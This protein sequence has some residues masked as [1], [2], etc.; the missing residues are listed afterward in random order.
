[1][2]SSASGDVSPN[3]VFD[4]LSNQRRRM[5]L[6]YLRQA[7]GRMS[8]KELAREIAALENEVPVEE[9][10]SQ[11]RKRV[12]VSLYQTHLPKLEST[13]MVDFDDEGNVQLTDRA[14]EIDT[15]LTPTTESTYPWQYHYLVLAAFG[16]GLILLRLL[17]VPLVA[18]VPL[19]AIAIGVT[20]VF[21]V[22]AS[23]HYWQYRRQREQV[24]QELEVGP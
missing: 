17:S 8:V 7:D 18:S 21:V 12:Y 10:T 14:A 2:G 15:Y 16:A 19:E 22:S 20:G 3:L 11:Q 9:L 4:I 13:E 6:Y 5:V 1:M 23:I 24:P